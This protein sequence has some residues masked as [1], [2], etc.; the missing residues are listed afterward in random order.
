MSEI[1]MQIAIAIRVVGGAVGPT[2][3]VGTPLGS[4]SVGRKASLF[5]VV[6]A[7]QLG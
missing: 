3:V 2:F 5:R 6:L 4:G 1:L 7:R